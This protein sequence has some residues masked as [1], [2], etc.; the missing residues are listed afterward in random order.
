M[1]GPVNWSEKQVWAAEGVKYRTLPSSAHDFVVLSL[2][3][4]VK[5]RRSRAVLSMYAYTDK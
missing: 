4:S 2:S 5:E 3:I 1:S